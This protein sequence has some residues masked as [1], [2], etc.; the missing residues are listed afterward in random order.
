[1]GFIYFCIIVTGIAACWLWIKF[2]RWIYRSVSPKNTNPYINAHK[3]IIENTQNYEEYIK[4]LDKKNIP[5]VP[6]DKLKYAEE[7][8][9]EEKLNKLLR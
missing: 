7:K 3:K 9:Q 1:M 4:W 6:L 5:G 8:R 2:C